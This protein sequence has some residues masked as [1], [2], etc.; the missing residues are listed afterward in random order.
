MWIKHTFDFYIHRILFS[1]FVQLFFPPKSLQWS[2]P[3]F[4]INQKKRA[5]LARRHGHK[6][7]G[8]NKREK[9]H[10][11]CRFFWETPFFYRLF[12]SVL[13]FGKVICL[14]VSAH[15][16][17]WAAERW[18]SHPWRGWEGG[19]VRHERGECLSESGRIVCHHLPPSSPPSSCL[20]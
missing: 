18:I 20:S 10:F 14:R 19:S 4:E 8:S 15:T 5:D 17:P 3:L 1:V 7:K 12:L 16:G 6:V 11:S 9:C 2:F 13:E